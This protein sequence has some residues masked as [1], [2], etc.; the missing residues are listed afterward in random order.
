MFKE[1][2]SKP[3]TRLAHKITDTDSV[4]KSE[5]KES[6][7]ILSIN[8]ETEG[9]GPIEFK[10]YDKPCVGDYV[11]RLLENNDGGEELYH[12]RAEVFAERNVIPEEVI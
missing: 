9:S 1:Y 8:T 11:V 2:E 4:V 6:T 7:F 10:A 3:I 5:G 12:C